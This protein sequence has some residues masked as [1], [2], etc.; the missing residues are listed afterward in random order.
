[1]A[2]RNNPSEG[3]EGDEVDLGSVMPEN[4]HRGK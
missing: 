1:M 3:D 2:A 4:T